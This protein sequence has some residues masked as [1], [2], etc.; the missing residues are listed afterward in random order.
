MD[1]Q[2]DQGNSHKQGTQIL[3]KIRSSPPTQVDPEKS[4]LDIFNQTVNQTKFDS[5]TLSHLML[6][7]Q[8]LIFG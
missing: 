7:S 2:V 3:R 1:C 5:F 4:H 8:R 6:N